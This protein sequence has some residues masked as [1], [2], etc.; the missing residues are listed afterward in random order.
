MAVVRDT[1][2]ATEVTV[3]TVRATV[4]TNDNWEAGNNFYLRA[5]QALEEGR[6]FDA[7]SL[8]RRARVL[9]PDRIEVRVLEN[10]A[11][12]KLQNAAPPA[13]LQADRA[14]YAR[15]I[16][17]YRLLVE[18]DY[19]PAF[20]LFHVLASERPDDPDVRNYLTRSQAGLSQS[21]FFF[22]E[23]E[24]A[25]ERY[26]ALPLNLDLTIGNLH[27]RLR[28]EMAMAG[29]DGIFFKNF[30]YRQDGA[31]AVLMG[32]PLARLSGNSLVAR[33]VQRQQPTETLEPLWQSDAA[34]GLAILANLPFSEADV[35][36]AMQFS[37]QPAD[38]P[39]H[40]L[41]FSLDEA[42]R[43]GHARVVLQR[44][45]G[46]RL[47]YPFAMIMLVLVGIALGMRFRGP[48]T[49][50]AA[51][52]LIGSPL[53]VLLASLPINIFQ[54]GSRLVLELLALQASTS[55]FL[56]AWLGL[57]AGTT[58]LGLLLAVKIAQAS[59]V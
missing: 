1:R 50:G 8:A 44:E 3:P 31:E 33:A 45:L 12:K 57:L 42:V 41:L 43:L 30:T 2:Q 4:S 18:E 49:P 19:L 28:A 39:L 6:F 24:T 38:I 46:Q 35:R 27:V 53:L 55:G 25:L 7:Y 16:E 58:V 21:Y 22:D 29:P 26:R 47:A 59:P 23:Y 36:L 52:V 54:Q 15:K 56:A 51:S 5:R 20:R 13:E 40:L 14:F 17:G 34:S 11:W 32:S 9:Y 37:G 48:N 10:D